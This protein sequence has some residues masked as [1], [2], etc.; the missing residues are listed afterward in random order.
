M[1]AASPLYDLDAA[2][3]AARLRLCVVNED[4][5][6]LGSLKFVFQAAG[7]QV[8]SYPSGAQ[9]L[10]SS[11]LSGADGFVLDHRPRGVDGL[12]LAR[13][14]RA[15]GLRAPILLTTGIRCGPLEAF[16]SAVERV[17]PAPR[18]DEESLDRFVRMIEETRR[19]RGR[20]LRKTT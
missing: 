6:V 9:L 16:A 13:R 10:A 2:P 1:S 14:L 3:G 8:S 15:L 4:A 19:R 12:D 5:A 7:F 11:S 18:V 20:G 17:I